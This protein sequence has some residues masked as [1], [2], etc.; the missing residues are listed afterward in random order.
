MKPSHQAVE[1]NLSQR[2]EILPQLERA[3]GS[4]N[5][6]REP[7]STRLRTSGQIDPGMAKHSNEIV[8]RN[9]MAVK[10]QVQRHYPAE[11]FGSRLMKAMDE[12]R[13]ASLRR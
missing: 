4:E 11:Y 12:K 2:E 7:S 5:V 10:K 13:R 6:T 8:K 1:D 9:K 3:K